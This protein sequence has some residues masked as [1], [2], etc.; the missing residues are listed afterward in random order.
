MNKHHYVGLTIVVTL[1]LT[2][3][4]FKPAEVEPNTQR[5]SEKLLTHP[6]GLSLAQGHFEKTTCWFEQAPSLAHLQ[7]AKAEC[8]WFYTGT[9]N[10]G[11]TGVFRLPVVIFR[12]MGKNREDDPLVHLA[13]GPG[14]GAWLELP[15]IHLWVSWYN[16]HV[17]LK[18]DLVLFDQ[19]GSGM[20]EP[21]LHCTEF[22][23]V[24][25][26]TLLTSNTPTENAANYRAASE[27]CRTKLKAANLP[28]YHLGT[29]QSARDTANLLSAL[30]YQQWNLYGVSYG[31][32]LAIEIQARYPDKVRSLILDSVYDPDIHLFSEWP[33][34]YKR[35]I[36]R[37]FNYC[38][39]MGDCIVS[40]DVLRERFWQ[41]LDRL[42]YQ[43]IRLPLSYNAYDD[44]PNNAQSH[45]PNTTL[46]LSEKNN[47]EQRNDVPHLSHVVINDETLLAIIFNS[48]YVSGILSDL[49][50]LIDSIYHERTDLLSIYAEQYVQ[51]QFKKSF[52]DVSFWATE[53][54]DNPEQ[55]LKSLEHDPEFARI[56]YY[57]PNSYNMCDVWR[58][59]Q[60]PE[61]LVSREDRQQLPVLIFSGE[62][63]PITPIDWAINTAKDYKDNVYLFS[64]AGISH[65]VMDNKPCA[66]DL[67]Q[68]FL[69][70]PEQRP[71][72]DCRW[73]VEQQQERQWRMS[74]NH[75]PKWQ[76]EEANQTLSANTLPH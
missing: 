64:F 1:W 3:T 66:K 67:F 76:N 74:E 52:N 4:G 68:R 35:S 10:N 34:L 43:P 65:S 26:K 24:A 23:D 9:E 5:L 59:D 18:R 75:V 50:E 42:R 53:C 21:S 31:T 20:S 46:A 22:Q 14:S 28:F 51:Q 58:K 62:D 16:K 38:Q 25:R 7:Q 8:G 72:A 6:E 29:P 45:S 71:Y 56:Q 39:Q 47:F 73:E 37:I 13:G 19:R 61:K 17:N 55:P 11:E 12:Y 69:T 70:Q 30:G 36:K 54:H 63:D 2:L 44:I 33:T 57:L 49:P 27:Q 60:N 15:K 32:R 41:V 48:E 40:S